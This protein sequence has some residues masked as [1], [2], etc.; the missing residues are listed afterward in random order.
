MKSMPGSTWVSQVLS[1]QF[2]HLLSKLR[3]PIHILCS[4]PVLRR[5]SIFRN[6]NLCV[7]AFN[8]IDSFL[9]NDI[10]TVLIGMGEWWEEKLKYFIFH[11]Q[12]RELPA[13]KVTC[14]WAVWWRDSSL[15]SLLL[16][17]LQNNSLVVI[18]IISIITISLMTSISLK[19]FYISSLT[20]NIVRVFS[21]ILLLQ[22]IG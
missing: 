9:W 6:V 8:I 10:N 17:E 3:K 15:Q 2:Q 1:M 5:C 21:S 12:M 18:L 22:A 11:N 16:S 19:A 4:H 13:G 14:L 20:Q 7:I